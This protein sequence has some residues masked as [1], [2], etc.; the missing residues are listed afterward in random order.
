MSSSSVENEPKERMQPHP[1]SAN[2]SG[3][4]K[5]KG[6]IFGAWSPYFVELRHRDL[7]I[8]KNDKTDEIRHHY[9]ITEDTKIQILSENNK[10][11][12]QVKIPERDR[13]LNFAAEDYDTLASWMVALRSAAFENSR[14]SM[15][16]FEV[17]SVIGRGFFGKV[18]L[19]QGKDD[20]EYYA[21]KTVKKERLI[22]SHQIHTILSERKILAN[23]KH[24]FVVNLMFAFQTVSKFYIG[25]EYVP[26][27][28]L[29][30]LLQRTGI[31]GIDDVRIYAGELATAIEHLH[32]I[33]VVYRDLKPENVLI[34]Q[35]GHLKL[36][37][38]GLAKDISETNTTKTFCGTAEFIAPE[39]IFGKPYDY[40]VDWWSF[41]I[42]VYQMLYGKTPFYSER[43]D[44]MMSKIKYADPTF[45]DT[46]TKDEIDFIKLFL[47][48]D[49]AKRAKYSDVENH[50]F[51]NGITREDIMSKKYTP[52]FIPIAR[53]QI[54]TEYFDNM[55]TKENPIDSYASPMLGDANVFNGFSFID[56]SS[57]TQDE[58][59]TSTPPIVNV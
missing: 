54:S 49:P 27:G 16:S 10:P 44:S 36:T 37:D 38:F 6:R 55:F 22:K 25:L 52:S 53:E 5:K 33:G 7:F 46:A 30:G 42:L 51:F 14:L 13:P 4:L 41:G 12:L 2:Q 32:S 15:N 48:K 29:I 59:S 19:V 24:P 28:D 39:I 57:T 17:I 11:F 56:D 21:L 45:P 40:C 58:A 50:P 9:T 20:R 26:G 47:E 31:V 8:R 18:L 35:D 43:R 23:A 34:G 3:W 1:A